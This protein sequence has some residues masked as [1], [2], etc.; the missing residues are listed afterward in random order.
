MY[1]RIKEI[2]KDVRLLIVDDDNNLRSSLEFT[3]ANYVK[4]IFACADAKTAIECFN[5]NNINLILSDIKMPKMSGINM[6]SIIRKEDENVPII[7]LTA[8]DDDENILSAIELKSSAVLKKPFDKR[9]LIMS[10]SF[11]ANKFKSDFACV[12]LGNGFEFNAMTR[13]LTCDNKYIPLTKK[14]QSLL[15]LLLKN[16]SRVV[17]FEMIQNYVWHDDSCTSD[18][19]RS[20][21][22]KLRKKL[23]PELIQ[24]AQGDGYRI[25]LKKSDERTFHNLNYI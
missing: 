10:I 8:Y 12:V 24:N 18:A 3:L 11:A 25:N 6:A 2:L 22:Y 4:D 9:E 14:E 20:F 7:F 16:S 21:V 5:Q 23:Y 17:T 13:Q 1:S 15:H 19:I